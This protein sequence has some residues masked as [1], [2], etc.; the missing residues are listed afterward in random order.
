MT[1]IRPRV[2]V[3]DK[4]SWIS[5]DKCS[6]L[7]ESL[8]RKLRAV[9]LHPGRSIPYDLGDESLSWNFHDQIFTMRSLRTSCRP[10]QELSTQVIAWIGL[11]NEHIWESL[12]I[13]SVKKK[14]SVAE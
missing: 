7:S 1:K 9:F 13:Q 2:L 11:N 6:P 10:R 5:E 12:L 3:F 14:I 4:G 8:S